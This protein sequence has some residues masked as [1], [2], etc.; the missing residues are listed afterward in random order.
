[1]L[2]LEN[3]QVKREGQEKILKLYSFEP[4]SLLI[5]DPKGLT[6]P[7]KFP[8]FSIL[9]LGSAAKMLGIVNNLSKNLLLSIDSIA[10]LIFNRTQ[11]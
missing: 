2:R 7:P 3:K 5:S 9:K 11:H 6:S 4:S 10:F 8:H 1:M